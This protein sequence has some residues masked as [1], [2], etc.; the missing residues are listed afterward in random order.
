VV[1]G[2]SRLAGTADQKAYARFLQKGLPRPSTMRYIAGKAAGQ[3]GV[4][5]IAAF[6]HDFL[7]GCDPTVTAI[8]GIPD[9][10]VIAAASDQA[11]VGILACFSARQLYAVIADHL[12]CHT[13]RHRA[14]RWLVGT[15]GVWR[16]AARVDAALRAHAVE[17]VVAG[18]GSASPYCP[19]VP[20][21]QAARPPGRGLPWFVAG[22]A[23]R[24]FPTE[25]TVVAA[26]GRQAAERI[27]RRVLAL[28]PAGRLH[29]DWLRQAGVSDVCLRAFA[30][31]AMAPTR[32]GGHLALKQLGAR[33]RAVI[34]LMVH[35]LVTAGS[36]SVTRRVAAPGEAA[37]KPCVVVVCTWCGSLR[38]RCRGGRTRN[39][40]GKRTVW[41]NFGTGDAHCCECGKT[42]LVAIDVRYQMLRLCRHPKGP[43]TVVAQCATCGKPVANPKLIGA[44]W[45]CSACQ[46]A[47]G[48]ESPVACQFCRAPPVQTTV[49][50]GGCVRIGLCKRHSL[51][52]EHHYHH[53]LGAIAALVGHINPTKPQELDALL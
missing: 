19:R 50:R 27:H 46:G 32:P 42:A 2:F 15:T 31:V 39:L 49:A 1:W 11:L 9:R 10:R 20:K 24:T 6:A 51:K 12:V 3:P 34:S 28:G 35:A 13:A 29:T 44:S 5:S 33:D 4:A 47:I 22:F 41:L 37:R 21:L 38:T 14:L 7:L 17:C 8:P 23:N 40:P 43:T 36:Y 48:L 53:S 52:P 45:L 18:V 25:G 26:G 30:A 16:P